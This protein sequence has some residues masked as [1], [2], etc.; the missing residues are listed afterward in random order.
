MLHQIAAGHSANYKT[1]LRTLI[2]VSNATKRL[3]A[4]SY[5][6]MLCMCLS[7]SMCVC[8][9]MY[10]IYEYVW[11]FQWVCAYEYARVFP[12]V[13]IPCNWS[14][15][16]N[17]KKARRTFRASKFDGHASILPSN[18]YLT[19]PPRDQRHWLPNVTHVSLAIRR[20]FLQITLRI[21]R[22]FIK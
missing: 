4:V 3:V 2:T 9:S 10:F 6:E 18:F 12:C 13:F 17:R 21:V 19:E 22:R 5:D 20:K 15:L 16:T 7:M 1:V 14:F 11:V 8:I